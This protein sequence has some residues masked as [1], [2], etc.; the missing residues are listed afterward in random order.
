M[1]QRDTDALDISTK[2]QLYGVLWKRPFGRPSSKWSRRFFIIKDSFLLYYAEN[3][4]RNF[5]TNRYFNIHPK[6]VLPLGG[7]VVNSNE[8]QGMPFTLTIAHQDFSGNIVLAA[9]SELE[10]SQWVRQLQESS[11]V[12]WKNSLLGE[13]M[14]E[15][16]EAQGLQLAKEKQ[17]YL[18]K[19][20]IE[21]EE[22]SLQREQ[23]EE[24]K[25]LNELL[26]EENQK[27]EE[28]VTELRMEQEQIKMDLDGTTQSLKAVELEK[29]ELHGLTTMLQKSLEELAQEKQQTLELLCT[30][31]PEG[32]EP[33]ETALGSPQGIPDASVLQGNL[34]LIEDRMRSLQGEKE[35]AEEKLKTNEQQAHVLQEEREFYYSQA[36]TL[37]LSLAELTV[38]K[39]NTEAELKA[40]IES[41]LELEQRLK[42]AEEA[43]QSLEEGLNSLSR[44]REKEERMKGDVRQLRQFF[45]ECICAAEIEAKLPAIMKNAVYIHKATVRRIKSCRIRKKSPRNLRGIRQSQSFILPPGDDS[46]LEDLKKTARQVSFDSSLRENV[47]K[48]IARHDQGQD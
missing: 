17:Q 14:I 25:R 30:S 13:A 4:K 47:Y 31:D 21:T 15:S 23:K 46:S 8:V 43:L 27:F 3:E 20:M 32:L 48:I 39:E 16:L 12:T 34:Q 9:E 19:L 26:E 45:E 38:D 1:E 44:S 22:L 42:V 5:E 24:L 6:G 29:E 40:E 35:Q 7:C 11:K 33:P 18:D 2:V 10:Q 41:K 28:V 37:Q 36:Q